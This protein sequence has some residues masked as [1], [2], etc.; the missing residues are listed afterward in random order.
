VEDAKRTIEADNAGG[1]K[2]KL[3]PNKSQEHSSD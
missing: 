1:K 3:S 2:L